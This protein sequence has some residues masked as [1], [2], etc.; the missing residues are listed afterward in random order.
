VTDPIVRYF[1]D[2]APG[3]TFD[4]GDVTVDE[5]SIIAFAKD[6]DPQPFHVD[7]TARANPIAASCAPWSRRGTSTTSRC[8]A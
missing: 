8:C 6:Y 1:D 2:Y 7:P 5:A 3:V 4:C